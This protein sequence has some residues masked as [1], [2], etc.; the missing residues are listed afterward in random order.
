MPVQAQLGCPRRITAYLQEQ[1]SEL[2][3][4]KVEVVVV[5]VNRLVARELE[6]PVDLLALK[7]L[8]LFLC[9]SN[10]D[11]AVAHPALLPNSVGDVILALPVIELVDRDL[12]P[13]RQR[14]YRIPKPRGCP[15]FR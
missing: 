5:H 15:E 10:E 9:D 3:I 12:L 11:D 4:V 13:L 6:L 7:C 8:R 1:R 14:L 2:G